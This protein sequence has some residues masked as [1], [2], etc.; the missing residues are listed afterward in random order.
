M[1]VAAGFAFAL[2]AAAFPAGAARAADDSDKPDAVP[3]RPTVSTPAALSAPGWL[4]GE[5]GGFLIRN[6][7]ADDGVDRRTSIP[8]TLKYA[9]T[10]DWG[11][12]VGGEAYAHGRNGDGSTDSGF[13]DTML[14]AKRRFA[15]DQASAFG[16]E[17]GAA[18]PTARSALQTGSG[19]TDWSLNGIYSADVGAWHAD[20][21]LVN[22][23]L[24]AK[25]EGQSRLQTLGAFA[26]SRPVSE[27]WTAAAELSGTRQRG[28]PGTAQFL[29][30]MS[31]A[32]RRDLV[33]DFG[34]AHGLNRASPTWQAFAGV[35][36]VLGRLD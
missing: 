35:T 17:V 22:T 33:V 30:A 12:R 5:F 20:V 9:F 10:D 27:R 24:G 26:L 4:E 7:H 14:V 32:L 2:L 23:R 16:L 36:L 3:Y 34:A 1:R 13:G 21:N 28:A 19:K 6:R 8:Y 15:I 31:V 25:S 29:A 18:F 11:L